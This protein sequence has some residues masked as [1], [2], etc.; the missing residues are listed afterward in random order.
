MSLTNFLL[1]GNKC[2]HCSKCRHICSRDT[3]KE[4]KPAAAPKKKVANVIDMKR[5]QNASIALARIK[6]PF[7][8]VREKV[9]LME[10]GVFTTD[11]LKSLE[12]M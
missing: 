11:Q 12:V 9:E 3:A 7:S 8:E 6:L 1:R 5:A 2:F 4:V 10:D